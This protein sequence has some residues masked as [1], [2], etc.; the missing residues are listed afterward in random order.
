MEEV[1]KNRRNEMKTIGNWEYKT[2]SDAL[3]VKLIDIKQITFNQHIM[4][5]LKDGET[6]INKTGRIEGWDN[7]YM[8][9][10]AK[11]QIY[12]IYI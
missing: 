3:T 1:G 4:E 5:E 11:T 10:E 8:K 2:Q 12:K 6:K 7:K 9:P